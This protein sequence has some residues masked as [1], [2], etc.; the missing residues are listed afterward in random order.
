MHCVRV[1]K[2]L[3]LP[4]HPPYVNCSQL[5]EALLKN[6]RLIVVAVH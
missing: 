4:E 6:H 3:R 1:A 5:R 2:L